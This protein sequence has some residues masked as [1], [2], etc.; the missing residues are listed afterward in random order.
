VD[1]LRTQRQRR[2]RGPDGIRLL[3]R[4]QKVKTKQAE[5]TL[6]TDE[7]DSVEASCKRKQRLVSGGFDLDVDFAA[8]RAYAMESRK[9]GRRSWEVAALDAGGEPH[10]LIGYA[11]C[12]KKKAK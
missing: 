6:N 3:P 9:V 11:Y 8:T 7:F 10:D 4:G 12:E 1:R 5:E 2:G